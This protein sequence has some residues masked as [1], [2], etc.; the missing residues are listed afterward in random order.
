MIQGYIFATIK[1]GATLQFKYYSKPGELVWVK[2]YL[3]TV[4]RLASSH[5][6]Y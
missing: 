6:G 3:V 5:M 4:F 2:Y 1:Q